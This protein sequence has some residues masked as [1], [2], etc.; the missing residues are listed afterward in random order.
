M[1]KKVLL[2]GESWFK[3]EVHVKG[4]DTFYS[5]TYDSGEKWLKNALEANGYQVDYM[6]NH[7]A[8]NE[9]PYETEAL[10]EYDTIILS[11]IGAN[12]LLLS[13]A[14]F[15][16]SEIKPNRIQ[17][18]KD[19]VLNGGG[20]CMIGGY[21]TFAGIDGKGRWHNTPVQDILPVQVLD[22]D[23]REEHPEG[24]V[25]TVKLE[26]EILSG[27]P[28]EWPPFLGYNKTILKENAQLLVEVGGNPL[29][30]VNT[31]GEGRVSVF[32][33]DCAPHWAPLQFCEWEYYPK[34]FTQLMDWTSKK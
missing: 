30:A 7:L 16:K 27:I 19:Y 17:L 2:V 28:A 24:I 4:F 11:D 3:Y 21:M 5:S 26:H 8:L 9:F 12:T 29:I 18:I 34:L 22:R 20:L 15:S 6:P 25:A 33:S 31:A 10:A 14:T 23:D 1:A 32:T 13:D